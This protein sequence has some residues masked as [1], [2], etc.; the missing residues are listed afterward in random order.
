M[1]PR[2]LPTSLSQRL[3]LKGPLI[4]APLGGG[5]T[6]PELVA[7]S[8]NAGA[9]GM[10]AGAYL[11]P[12]ELTASIEKTRSLTSK[13][14]GINLF[15]PSPLPEFTRAEFEAAC[16]VTQ[17]YRQQL[18]LPQPKELKAPFHHDFQKQFE[19]VLQSK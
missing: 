1:G 15:A 10:L 14:F 6:T 8:S 9:L 4:V 19:I 13:P 17:I 18:G 11:S 3:K 12:D 16:D 2:S 7:A 5:P